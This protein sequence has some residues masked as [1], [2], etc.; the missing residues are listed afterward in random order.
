MNHAN[1]AFKGMR[2]NDT[3]LKKSEELHTS[4]SIS[5]GGKLVILQAYTIYQL[6]PFFGVKIYS[7]GVNL[8]C[9]HFINP[10][11]PS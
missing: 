4:V 10:R 7:F 11:I 8:W 9:A 6:S 3:P 1:S 5:I 2:N